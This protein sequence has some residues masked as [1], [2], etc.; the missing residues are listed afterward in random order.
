[1]GR[2]GDGWREVAVKTFPPPW[3][4]VRLAWLYM[5][6]GRPPVLLASD[7][8]RP[9]FHHLGEITIGPPQRFRR[10]NGFVYF[11]RS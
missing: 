9:L 10:P 4:R 3:L 5:F 1:M 6:P 8:L 7:W 11:L 2:A